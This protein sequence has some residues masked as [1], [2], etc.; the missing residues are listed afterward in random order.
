MK[1]VTDLS[2]RLETMECSTKSGRAVLS[3]N[4]PPVQQVQKN[5]D[6]SHFEIVN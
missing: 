5:R 6:P 3:N 4:Q 2:N 1:Q